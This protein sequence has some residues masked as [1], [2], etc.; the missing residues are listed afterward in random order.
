MPILHLMKF[1]CICTS[2]YKALSPQ[3]PLTAVCKHPHPYT[4]LR[5]QILSIAM[6]TQA[7]GHNALALS[8]SSAW[9]QTDTPPSQTHLRRGNSQPDTNSPLFPQHQTPNPVWKVWR[10]RVPTPRGAPSKPLE[11]TVHTRSADGPL[12]P[13]PAAL[14]ARTL[15]SQPGRCLPCPG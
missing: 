10:L 6:N 4:H 13:H 7:W 8:Q 1:T 14:P 11:V 12:Q 9:M 2:I 15:C 3:C 5:S